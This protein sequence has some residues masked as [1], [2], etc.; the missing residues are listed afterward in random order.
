LEQQWDNPG[1]G[2]SRILQISGGF[3]YA[4]KSEA[5]TGA[6]VVP[7]SVA[8]GGVPIEMGTGYRVTVNSFLADG[9]DQLTVLR[10]GAGG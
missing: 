2:Q 4:W 1:P 6:K 7:G 5:A 3:S 10:D 9:G 8:I